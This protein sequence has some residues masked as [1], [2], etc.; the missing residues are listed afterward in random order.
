[1]KDGRYLFAVPTWYAHLLP[2]QWFNH[3]RPYKTKEE[4][5]DTFRHF[6]HALIYLTY[7]QECLVYFR[8]D[9]YVEDVVIYDDPDQIREVVFNTLLE[10]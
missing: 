6:N 5:I 3:L 8:S 9:E 4:V 2:E 1:M 10:N 7:D